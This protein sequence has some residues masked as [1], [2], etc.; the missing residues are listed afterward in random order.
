MQKI[1]EV[2]AEKISK[3]ITKETQKLIVLKRVPKELLK[4]NVRK[5]CGGFFED[6]FHA[7]IHRNYST[8]YADKF[9]GIHKSIMWIPT[10]RLFNKIADRILKGIDEEIS[11]RDH[12]KHAR[13]R[14]NS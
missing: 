10:V 13:K 8:K 6:D 9:I 5:E 14:Y 11:K 3:E 4:K 7:K 12:R 2:N 1:A